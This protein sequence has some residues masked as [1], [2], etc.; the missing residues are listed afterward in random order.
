M[1]NHT[2]STQPNATAAELP[3]RNGR[4]SN[5]GLPNIQ[6]VFNPN[7]G[8]STAAAAAQIY[9]P[10]GG[11]GHINGTYEPSEAGSVDGSGSRSNT[12]RMNPRGSAVSWS[13]NHRL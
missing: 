10:V 13:N 6:N 2:L 4:I 5:A 8:L 3:V 9:G 11:G 7:G 12:L 1:F